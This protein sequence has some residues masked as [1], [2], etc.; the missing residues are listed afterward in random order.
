[1][2]ADWDPGQ[3]PPAGDNRGAE[4][5]DA[6]RLAWLLVGAAAIAAGT[7]LGWDSSSL[8]DVVT[9]PTYIRAALIGI[10]AG[11]GIVLLA[12]ALNRL[13]VPTDG[14]GRGEGAP[15]RDIGTLIRGVRLVFLAVAAFAAASGWLLGHPLPLVVA[16]IIA[17]VD[18]L[19]TSFLLIVVGLQRRR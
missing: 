6:G 16:L 4:T 8:A 18:V 15:P 19:E 9:P 11:V 2:S 13:A 3:E 5:P 1:M 7:A 14:V 10:A 12:G 17:G